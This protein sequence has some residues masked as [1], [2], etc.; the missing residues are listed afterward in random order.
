[1]I[2]ARFW[3][4]PGAQKINKKSKKFEKIDFLTHAVSKEGSGR[5]LGGFWEDLGRFG[6]DLGR[7]WE[8]F[9]EGFLAGFWEDF[10]NHF[11]EGFGRADND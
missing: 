8:G 10:G 11:L 5:V 6:E 4:A 9:W 3:E 7:V 1:M 2:L